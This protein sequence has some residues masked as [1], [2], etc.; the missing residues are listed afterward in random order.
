MSRSDN[1]TPWWVRGFYAT[2]HTAHHSAACPNNTNIH[3]SIHPL[4]LSWLIRR[5]GNDFVNSYTCNINNLH[6][7]DRHND[8]CYYIDDTERHQRFHSTRRPSTTDFTL[9]YH[10]RD[11]ACVRTELI[12]AR[13]TANTLL[14]SPNDCT[15]TP[16]TPDDCICDPYDHLYDDADTDVRT[17]KHRHVPFNGGW[18]D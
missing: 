13:R 7:H 17:T 12:N 11:R 15:C 4:I 14:A 8:R 16:D 5:R 3:T 6:T 2:Q 1:T 9:F 10:R 18:W